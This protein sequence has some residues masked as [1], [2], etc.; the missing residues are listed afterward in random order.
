MPI[1][2]DQ[3]AAEV[4]ALWSS[5]CRAPLEGSFSILS[6]VCAK[7]SLGNNPQ[8]PT[9]FTFLKCP[10]VSGIVPDISHSAS[11]FEI[12]VT[13]F[14]KHILTQFL[15]DGESKHLKKC[16]RS[17]WLVAQIPFKFRGHVCSLAHFYVG[18]QS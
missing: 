11:N 6:V 5:H 8:Y 13:L 12:F 4:L 14:K 7:L 10:S 9:V 17:S 15:K 2:S 18:L 3:K 1:S 16:V